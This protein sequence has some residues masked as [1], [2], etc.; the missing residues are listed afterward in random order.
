M[1]VGIR[2]VFHYA[3]TEEQF[4]LICAAHCAPRTEN[5][6]NVPVNRRLDTQQLDSAKRT[7]PIEY[8]WVSFTA[9][10]YCLHR[11]VIRY[12]ETWLCSF[13]VQPGRV[14][15]VE[16]HVLREPVCNVLCPFPVSQCEDQL[17]G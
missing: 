12:L 14:A 5:L 10:L 8:A 13:R 15:T 7:G 3:L 6:D 4:T 2:S 1:F 17:K 16:L 9:P 11:F